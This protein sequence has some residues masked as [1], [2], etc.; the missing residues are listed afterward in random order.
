MFQTIIW[1]LENDVMFLSHH[2]LASALHINPWAK[3]MCG[4][5]AREGEDGGVCGGRV[6]CRRYARGR[7]VGKVDND[8]AGEGGFLTVGAGEKDVAQAERIGR[9]AQYGIGLKREVAEDTVSGQERGLRVIDDYVAT[10]VIQRAY[11]H[12]VAGLLQEAGGLVG[13]DADALGQLDAE[14]QGGE[15][16]CL[17][18]ADLQ[19]P[20]LGRCLLCLACQL[21]CLKLEAKDE[22]Q[23]GKK[24]YFHSR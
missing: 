22:E 7:V 21:L 2:E 12:L 10:C 1:F 13:A 24:Y 4:A 19:R 3:G 6:L 17:A 8:V 18:D 9:F 11:E 14:L 15:G 5:M 20:F 16:L 23:G